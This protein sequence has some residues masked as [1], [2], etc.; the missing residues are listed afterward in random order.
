MSE[1]SQTWKVSE[2]AA[3]APAVTALEVAA[4][5]S[6]KEKESDAKLFCSTRQEM[7]KSEGGNG[8]EN[9]RTNKLTS[10]DLVRHSKV[11]KGEGKS[12]RAHTHTQDERGVTPACRTPEPPLAV[13]STLRGPETMTSDWT[14]LRS[15]SPPGSVSDFCCF[16]FR[17]RE[18]SVCVCVRGNQST[19]ALFFLSFF[20]DVLLK[21]FHDAAG[22]TFDL[23][24]SSR[25]A[26][27]VSGRPPPPTLL[28]HPAT[29]W[30]NK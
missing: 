4:L 24:P 30:T 22:A 1:C 9:E 10:A 28:M 19:A 13:F 14:H 15:S 25:E 5:V 21:L 20:L 27:M 7:Q 8:K 26:A 29:T 16:H 18:S 23:R 3:A 2:G 12:K 6:E 17:L 11:K